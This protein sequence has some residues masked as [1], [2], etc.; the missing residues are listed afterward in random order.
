M[1][2]KIILILIMMALIVPLFS[3]HSVVQAYSGEIDPQNYITLPSIITVDENKMGTGTISLSSSASG[4]SI[5]YQKVDITQE[6]MNSINT[7]SNELQQYVETTNK[8]VK[9]KET[10]LK[11]LKNKYEQVNTSETA[12]QEEK[13]TAKNNYD[14][15]L[16]EY[17]DYVSNANQKVQTL[18]TEL[19]ALVPNYTNSWQSTTN[20]T[21]NLKLDFSN[22]SGTISFVVWVKIDN[23]TNTYYDCNVY[24]TEIKKQ[25]TQQPS[26]GDTTTGD[27]TDFSKA[28]YE[29]KKDGISGAI[30]EI[31][32]V[33]LKTDSNYYVYISSTADK[34]DLSK[35]EDKDMTAIRHN[36]ENGKIMTWDISDKVELNQDLYLNVIEVDS[37]NS[38]KEIVS[39]GI[40]LE[41]FAEG[42]YS[43][44]FHAT[45]VSKDS[46]QIVTTF[47]HSED[48]NRK[49]QIKIGKITDVA[50]LNK[51]KN[52][53]SSGFSD[54]LNYAKLSSSIY[55]KVLDADSKHVFIEYSA[56]DASSNKNENHSIINLPELENDAYYFLYVKTDD[57]NGKYISNEAVTLAQAD[58]LDNENWYL[59]FYGSS[60][61]KWADFGNV[62]NG[63]GTVTGGDNTIAPTIL[64]KAGIEKIIYI[65]MGLLIIG[66]GIV[67]YKKY[68]KYQGI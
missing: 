4:Y 21:K 45:F 9:N 28:T 7:K 29:L 37:L 40:K 50:I 20:S 19:Y 3:Y 14:T 16:K 56:G 54:L 30:I 15:A 5:S 41:R 27:W 26:G 11:E 8:E 67:S 58:V 68:K 36:K 47:T 51:I 46:T 43:D 63:G 23:G 33:T 53:D 32:G 64:P 48:N 52:Q 31:S 38:K 44:A 59:F 49:L 22:Y 65:G 25:E 60:D 35:I 6:T 66:A 34:P 17:N 62:S 13:T 10:N 57:E 24:S 42:K 61:F 12:T 2:K 39:S 55:D 18:K 1:K